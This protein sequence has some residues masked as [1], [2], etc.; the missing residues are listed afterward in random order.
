MTATVVA[1]LVDRGTLRWD[2]TL[3]EWLYGRMLSLDVRN[4]AVVAVSPTGA[5]TIFGYPGA[6]KA[7]GLAVGVHATQFAIRTKRI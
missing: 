3:A 1:R 7:G 5:V 6:Q 2:M 4:G